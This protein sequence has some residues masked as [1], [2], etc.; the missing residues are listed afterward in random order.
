[1]SQHNGDFNYSDG[2]QASDMTS[3]ISENSTQVNDTV[4]D[5]VT[6][7]A[8]AIAGFWDQVVTTLPLDSVFGI[9]LIFLAF[10]IISV[11]IALI[12]YSWMV[13]RSVKER[14]DDF[15]KKP[16]L[17]FI[18]R[19]TENALDSMGVDVSQTLRYNLRP[20]GTVYKMAE[21]S[22]FDDLDTQLK[23]L[24]RERDD[25]HFESISWGD[26]NKHI[27]SSDLQAEGLIDSEEKQKIDDD[28]YIPH[29]LLAVRPSGILGV[30]R[31][32]ISDI[33]YD[34]SE[35]TTFYLVP[36]ILLMDG[37]DHIQIPRNIQFRNI[38]G[39]EVPLY[40][41]SMAVM[42]SMV[43]RHGMEMALEDLLNYSERM[44][45]SDP[46]YVQTIQELIKRQELE[47]KKNEGNVA[48]DINN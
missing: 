17:E 32:L 47:E 13:R 20:L 38:G 34:H 46:D 19:D 28:G 11:L 12:G 27:D 5:T 43:Q 2:S 36:E 3:N 10:T 29:K 31:W 1:M 48:G 25:I 23:A 37:G 41:S 4:T 44:I 8:D 35:H 18:R 45:Y 16:I 26:L 22:E 15:E 14:E 6:S 39:V 40:R 7:N 33:I 9:V 30:I 24:S 42:F 21:Y